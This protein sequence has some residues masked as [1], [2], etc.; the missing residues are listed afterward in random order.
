MPSIGEKV[1][2]L[3]QEK[4]WTLKELSEKSGVSLSHISAIENGTRP[5][6]SILRVIKL[7]QALDVS[8]AYFD[9]SV[10]EVTKQTS[11]QSS[12]A[13]TAGS[14]DTM[15]AKLQ[16][17]YDPKTQAFIVSETSRPYVALAMQLAAQSPTQDPSVF[18]QLIA[19]FIRDQ[20]STYKST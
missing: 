20:N 12:S 18:L 1:A 3:R 4:G 17:L 15:E 19:Q 8:L 16:T 9:D 2:K 13:A 5:N 7:A 11:F 6:P 10:S 14:L